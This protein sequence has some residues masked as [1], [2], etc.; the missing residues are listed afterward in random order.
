MD[1]G[2]WGARDLAIPSATIERG[3]PSR[4]D[5]TTSRRRAGVAADPTTLVELG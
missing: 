3:G 2:R 4:D 5:A 1:V